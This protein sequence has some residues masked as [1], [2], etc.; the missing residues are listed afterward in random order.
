MYL[1]AISQHNITAIQPDIT[2]DIST[3]DH[4]AAKS[5]YVPSYFTLD[6]NRPSKRGEITAQHL[7]W[8]YDNCASKG[9]TLT[10]ICTRTPAV[11]LVGGLR[12][13]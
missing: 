13:R 1:G 2:I 9:W 4:A 8:A 10:L 6:F 5:G 3:D 11:I 12:R 7:A